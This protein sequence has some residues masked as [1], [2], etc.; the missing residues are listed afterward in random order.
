MVTGEWDKS[1]MTGTKYI[2]SLWGDRQFNCNLHFFTQR[3]VE[4]GDEGNERKIKV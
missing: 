3:Q 4:M 2:K 1:E